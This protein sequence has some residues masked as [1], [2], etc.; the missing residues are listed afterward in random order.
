MDVIAEYAPGLLAVVMPERDAGDSERAARTLL[1]KAR[2]RGGDALDVAV[3]V[4]GFPEHGT[5]PGTLI[6]RAVAA[7]DSVRGR[8]ADLVGVPPV[9]T[10]PVMG[11]IIV[12]DSQMARVYELVRKVADHPITVLVVGETGVGKE[13]I[14][15]AI[16]A[17]SHRR[18]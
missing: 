3:G 18:E 15:S 11:D 5:T 9:E 1:D 12:G 16:H 8:G 4:A 6:A 7:L 17:E 14:A 10:T 13:V 2:L